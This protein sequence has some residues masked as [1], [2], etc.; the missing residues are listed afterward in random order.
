MRKMEILSDVGYRPVSMIKH[1]AQ[2]D[3]RMERKQN[4]NGTARKNALRTRMV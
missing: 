3:M 1:S 4:A 2:R